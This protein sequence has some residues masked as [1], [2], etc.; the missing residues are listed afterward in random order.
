MYKILILFLCMF[1]TLHS[2]NY[3]CDNA[4]L[5]CS[6]SNLSTN[7]SSIGTQELNS[8]NRGCIASDE[9]ASA[10]YIL[11][12][13][14]SGTLT[15]TID[16]SGQ[17]D[18]DFAIQGPNVMCGSLG[19]PIRC[20]QA[21]PNAVR[22]CSGITGGARFNT[23]LA[24]T[25][26]DPNG[27]SESSGVNIFGACT[28]PRVNGF[29]NRLN[30]IAGQ[31]YILLVNNYDINNRSFN[32]SFGGTSV[33]GCTPLPIIYFSGL[34]KN[35][36]NYLNQSYIENAISYNIE[37][38]IDD[39]Q[40]FFNNTEENYLYDYNINNET[41]YRLSY[42]DINGKLHNT[43]I[44]TLIRE[45]N[46]ILNTNIVKDKLILNKKV[47]Y[48]LYDLSGKTILKGFD[49]VINFEELNISIYILNVDNKNY[50]I[51]K[52]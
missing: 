46:S 47:N 16:P 36:Y 32:L 44:L 11:N 42:I 10:Q 38:F 2:Q 27:N 17:A 22:T 28:N 12:I 18:Y 51:I 13:E 37:K 26:T 39:K 4:V 25:T 3:D 5:V 45:Q 8:S 9:D 20:S 40:V 48:V 19:N 41:I 29:V 50:K 49:D 15:F 34:V 33:L 1:F 35:N 43:K 7:P 14:S 23:G 52:Q 21:D 6:N 30:V 24:N 31:T